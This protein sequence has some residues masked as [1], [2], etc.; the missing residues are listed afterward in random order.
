MFTQRH[1]LLNQSSQSPV[2][3]SLTA[4]CCGR[5]TVP[6]YESRLSNPKRPRRFALPAHPKSVCLPTQRF[7][8]VA[9]ARGA[10]LFVHDQK[11]ADAVEIICVTLA[12]EVISKVAD[13]R[14]FRDV[15][16]IGQP[17]RAQ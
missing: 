17:I 5:A 10:E 12:R 7:W 9:N 13:V 11:C 6:T 2:R 3:Q 8:L 16:Q 15:D 14:P 1:S 4:L